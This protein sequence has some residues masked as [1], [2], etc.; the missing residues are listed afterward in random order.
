MIS[1]FIAKSF[2]SLMALSQDSD[3]VGVFGIEY[4]CERFNFLDHISFLLGLNI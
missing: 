1:R 4:S 2:K 3:V